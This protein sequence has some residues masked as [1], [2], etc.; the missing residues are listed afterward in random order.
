MYSFLV[1]NIFS[2]ANH[3]I[4]NT[5]FWQWTLFLWPIT[6]FGM[7]YKQVII[8]LHLT[9]SKAFLG[10]S[11]SFVESWF[12]ILVYPR[13]FFVFTFYDIIRDMIF[14]YINHF[15]GK[16]FL[17]FIVTE[18]FTEWP[19]SDLTYYSPKRHMY[20]QE[21]DKLLDSSYKK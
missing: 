8:T 7:T 17:S 6:V 13:C 11:R 5:H 10:K 14:K 3:C 20:L 18:S 4:W 16:H 9:I 21:G 12:D 19:Y 2:L 15:V 1:M